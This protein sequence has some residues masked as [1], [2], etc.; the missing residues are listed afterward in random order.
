MSKVEK[1]HTEYLFT[2]MMGLLLLLCSFPR[3]I[4]WV[5]VVI[6]FFVVFLFFT[7]S[8]FAYCLGFKF[9]CFYKHFFATMH[10]YH[11]H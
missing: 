4:V 11:V 5:C 6:F 3:L 9:F 1:L 10:L 7:C 2:K 8:F